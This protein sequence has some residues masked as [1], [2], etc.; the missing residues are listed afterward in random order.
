MV[1]SIAIQ[2]IETQLLG[3][4]GDLLSPARVVQMKSDMINKIAAES[5]ESRLQ[6]ERMTRKLVVLKAGFEMC[7]KHIGRPMTSESMFLTLNSAKANC[8]DLQHRPWYPDQHVF[9]DNSEPD[10]LHDISESEDVNSHEVVS[11]LVM[12]NVKHE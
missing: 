8:S 5:S 1:D 6:R 11:A 3:K 7:K 2:A 10:L 12:I 9:E 4:L